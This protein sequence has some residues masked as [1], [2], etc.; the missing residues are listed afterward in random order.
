MNENIKK[1]LSLEIEISNYLSDILE[2][3]NAAYTLLTNRDAI[4]DEDE[5]ISYL[6]TVPECIKT[7]DKL[8]E[9]LEIQYENEL[10][11]VRTYEQL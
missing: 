9:E 1:K 4:N 7:L 6:S 3:T 11:E 10:M 8:I 5:V 2:Y